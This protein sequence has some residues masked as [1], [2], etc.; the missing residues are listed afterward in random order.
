M[1]P[2]ERQMQFVFTLRS[3]GVKDTH[4]L[5]AMEAV[6]R[7]AF[8]GALFRNRAW[9]DTALPISCGQ[10]ISSPS[11][12][13]FMTQALEISPR[14]KVLEIGTGSGYQTAIL[15]RLA[16]RV[17]SVERH[18]P[19]AVEAH[20]LLTNHG[21]SNVIVL[22]GDGSQ[23][24]PEQAPFDRILVTAAAEDVPGTLLAQLKPGGILVMPVGQTDQIQTLIKVIK[25]E[26]GLEYKELQAVRFV[27][28]IEGV[29]EDSGP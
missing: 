29:A 11:I 14:S 23:G 5:Q 17:Y 7:D 6:A 15:A 13:G 2:E 4:V 19:L 3:A 21:Y 8:V 10:T 16:R 18:R 20:K 26:A 12:V 28:L 25:T 1:T 27:P 22:S 9:E 24:L